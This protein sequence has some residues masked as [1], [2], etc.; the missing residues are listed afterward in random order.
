MMMRSFVKIILSCTFNSVVEASQE[1]G[2]E[3]GPEAGVN[4][5]IPHSL[6]WHPPVRR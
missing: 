4:E 1:E 5:V 6:I 3:V 2:G